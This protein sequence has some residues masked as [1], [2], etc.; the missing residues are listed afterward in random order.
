MQG[1]RG[2]RSTESFLE[3]GYFV[4][5]LHR[6][7]S[8]MPFSSTFR[9]LLSPHMDLKFLDCLN[10][11]SNPHDGSPC[12]V[13]RP[14]GSKESN[15]ATTLTLLNEL[16]RYQKHRDHLLD[17]S[18]TSIDEYLT[19]LQAISEKITKHRQNATKKRETACCSGVIY[20]LAAAVS[21]FYI[22]PEHMPQHKIQSGPL[23]SPPQDSQQQKIQQ[24][25]PK[26]SPSAAPLLRLDL[27]PVPKRL[28]TLVCEWAPGAFVTS[29]KLET[30]LS[31]V[32]SKAQM[33]LQNYSVHLV[34][35]NQLQVVALYCTML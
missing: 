29:F 11:E 32:I 8:V 10:T 2:A 19:L 13:L 17:I 25:T 35:A 4:L 16:Q 12:L 30:D 5:L 9:N 1:E 27:H 7:G 6:C 18:F 22:P 21:D 33:A 15:N 23:P 28:G 24:S 34:V 14:P 26:P 31:L 20:Y 3:Q